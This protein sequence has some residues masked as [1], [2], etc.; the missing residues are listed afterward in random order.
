MSS[1]ENSDSGAAVGWWQPVVFAAMAGGMGWGIR[2]QY[3]HETGAMIAGVLVS[4]TLAFLMCPGKSPLQLVRAVALATIAMGF[5]GS[6]S[7]GQTVGLTHDGPLVGHCG[8]FAWGMLGLGIKGGIWIGFAGFFLGLG[9]GGKRYRPLEMLKLVLAMLLA[10]AV[11]WSILNRPHNPE[12]MLLP[13]L[14]F[15]DHWYWEPEILG[16]VRHRPEVWGGLLFALVTAVGYAS[17]VKK[18]TLA[19]NMALWG[20]L[21]GALGFPF[22]QCFQASNAWFPGIFRE[23]LTERLAH[24]NAVETFFGTFMG[25]VTG[26]GLWFNDGF[27]AHFTHWNSMETVFGAVMGGVLGLGLWLNRKK[28]DV[29]PDADDRPMPYW[30]E[31]VLLAMH[32]FLLIAMSFVGGY[33]PDAIYDFGMMM[34]LIPLVACIRGRFWPYLQVLPITLLPIAGKTLQACGLGE[35]THTEPGVAW[36]VYFI[37]PMAAATAFAIWAGLK[38]ALGDG[39]RTFV[40]DALLFTA[41]MYFWLNQAFFSFPWPYIGGGGR[42]DDGLIFTVCALGLT[43]MVLINRKRTECSAAC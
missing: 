4:L 19:R 14:Y 42:V 9:L 27:V 38:T 39:H 31:G 37:V 3:G 33:W 23:G 1:Q 12:N 29:T 26:V 34:G 20:F 11:G 18:D 30:G 43:I 41:W 8:A 10:V 16:K 7:Y 6:M 40:R 17:R 25:K 32:L 5:G 21:G 2:G 22:G 13:L 35:Q 28:I 24:W 15:S 36:P